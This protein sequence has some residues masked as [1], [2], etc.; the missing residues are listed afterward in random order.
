MNLE[1]DPSSATFTIELLGK[2]LCRPL[3]VAVI[4]HDPLHRALALQ[5]DGMS[6]HISEDEAN[7]LAGAGMRDDR[8][9][10][11]FHDGASAHFETA[12][13]G[14]DWD[15]IRGLLREI[16]KETVVAFRPRLYAESF[17]VARERNGFALGNQDALK[18][19]AAQ[20]ETSLASGGF[21]EARPMSRFGY[22]NDYLLTKQGHSLLELLEST[23]VEAKRAQK[24]LMQEGKAALTK[25]GFDAVLHQSV[26]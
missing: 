3:A 18:R 7:R 21:I 12:G 4:T 17:V 6:I 1:I 9:R 8:S 10:P 13:S 5:F 16:G 11:G 2:A 14:Y 15:L 20:Y 25:Q 19:Q 22:G 26:A 24:A 23:S